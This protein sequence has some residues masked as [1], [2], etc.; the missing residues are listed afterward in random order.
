MVPLDPGIVEISATSLTG[1]IA[2]IGGFAEQDS[3][4]A[5]G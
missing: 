2:M 3:L 5:V 4:P 1:D